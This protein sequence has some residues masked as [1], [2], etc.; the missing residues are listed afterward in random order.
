MLRHKLLWESVEGVLLGARDK[1]LS[2][3]RPV[4]HSQHN[5]KLRVRQH[6]FALLWHSVSSSMPSSFT[7]AWTSMSTSR[8]R[9]KSTIRRCSPAASNIR[10]SHSFWSISVA[11]SSFCISSTVRSCPPLAS[12]GTS[13]CDE[14]RSWLGAERS[15]GEQTNLCD[16]HARAWH[17]SPQYGHY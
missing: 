8:N 15:S 6:T 12:A 2:R 4:D 7:P 3:R 1:V 10:S 13:S 9:S 14:R 5:V 17:S 11:A 16:G